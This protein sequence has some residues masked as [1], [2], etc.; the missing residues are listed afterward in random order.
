MSVFSTRI[1]RKLKEK[2]KKYS[3]SGRVNRVEEIE[4]IIVEKIREFEAEENFKK[5]LREL[6]KA[7][8]SVPKGFS[9]KSVREDRDDD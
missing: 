9:V 7:E 5:I 8:W 2:M 6:E 1:G 3:G 4:K